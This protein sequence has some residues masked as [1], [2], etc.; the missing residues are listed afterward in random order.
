MLHLPLRKRLL[1][2]I[3]K[4]LTPIFVIFLFITNVHSQNWSKRGKLTHEIGFVVGGAFFSTDYG[5]RFEIKS[6]GASNVGFGGGLV[7]YLTFADYRY[8]WNQRTNYFRDHFRFRTELS[9]FSAKLN[10]Y[11]IY[12][13]ESQTST[14]ADKLRAMSGKATTVNLGTQLEYHF[15]NITDFGSR[16]N[17][18]MILSPYVSFGMMGV[19]SAPS[20]STT[21]ADGDWESDPTLLYEKWAVP[22]AVDVNSRIIFSLTT[23][24]GTRL[25]I[26]EYSDIFIEAKWQYY[27]SDW[28]DGLNATQPYGGDNRDPNNL[29]NDWSLFAN[30]G[31]IFYLN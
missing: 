25:K 26:G 8:R 16:R 28:V 14:E 30:V 19:Y 2:K 27:F 17:P 12:V 18:K 11:G 9:Y 5:Q 31:Y 7:Y 15:V 4:I 24:A 3:T 1:N 23:S 21:Y 22:G 10:H 20:L 13:D 29:F 6:S